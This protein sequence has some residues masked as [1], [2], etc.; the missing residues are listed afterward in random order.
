MTKDVIEG[1]FGQM[2]SQCLE[3]KSNHCLESTAAF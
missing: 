2:L 3:I 1:G